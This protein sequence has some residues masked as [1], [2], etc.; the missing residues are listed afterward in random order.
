[1]VTSR[2]GHFEHFL[3][4]GNAL[5]ACPFNLRQ[6]LATGPEHSQTAILDAFG[7]GQG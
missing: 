5:E 3:R 6:G 1:V 4:P 7:H 2:L